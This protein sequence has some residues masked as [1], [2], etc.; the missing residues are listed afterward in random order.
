MA[1][2]E[3]IFAFGVKPILALWFLPWLLSLLGILGSRLILNLRVQAR[4]DYTTPAVPF[5]PIRRRSNSSARNTSLNE[6]IFLHTLPARGT[7]LDSYLNSSLVLPATRFSQPSPF[8]EG[9]SP[10]KPLESNGPIEFAP[11]EPP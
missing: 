1:L 5:S 10:A 11:M 4:R 7:I 3:I 8:S 9:S 2:L 6:G